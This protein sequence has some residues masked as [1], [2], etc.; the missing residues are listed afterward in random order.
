MEVVTEGCILKNQL[1]RSEGRS[2]FSAAN[3]KRA[4]Q[5]AALRLSR[6]DHGH[7]KPEPAFGASYLFR[8]GRG[9]DLGAPLYR[10]C[11][12]NDRGSVVGAG[13]CPGGGRGAQKGRR[14]LREGKRQQD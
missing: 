8:F 6:K 1:T 11:G 2:K 3:K 7:G 10:Q 12:G 13:L 9:R 4:R 5:R 14:R